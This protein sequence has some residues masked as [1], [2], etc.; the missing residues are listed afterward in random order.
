M[1]IPAHHHSQLAGLLAIE[2]AHTADTPDDPGVHLIRHQDR[3]WTA[4]Y[5]GHLEGEP[6][7]HLT[8]PGHPDGILLDKYGIVH[9]VTEPLATLII[10][11]FGSTCGHCGEPVL[12]SAFRHKD[13]SGPGRRPG[14]G[15]GAR[16]V[17]MRGRD[18][19][20]TDHILRRTRPDLLIRGTDDE[21]DDDEGGITAA[22]FLGDGVY[23]PE[24]DPVKIAAAEKRLDEIRVRLNRPTW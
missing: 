17:D 10:G 15:C 14:G 22:D 4:E 3:D 23:R 9:A 19:S 7:W 2:G 12:A 11:A 8:G 13:I 6:I 20:I 16:F 24:T 5:R 21:P 1:G 18:G